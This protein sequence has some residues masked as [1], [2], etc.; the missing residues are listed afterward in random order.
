MLPIYI[1]FFLK[2]KAYSKI[3]EERVMAI[4]LQHY[5]SMFYGES[6]ICQK[7]MQPPLFWG[8]PKSLQMGTAAMK[9]KDAYSFEEKLGPTY[10][11][12]FKAET[13]LCRLRSA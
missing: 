6:M 13:L 8:A 12:Y 9:L 10:I 2:L 4:H 5:Y 7:L 11:A 3:F 1:L